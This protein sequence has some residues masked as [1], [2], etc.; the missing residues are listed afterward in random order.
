MLKRIKT[1]LFQPQCHIMYLIHLT[2]VLQLCF[3]GNFFLPLSSVHP[4]PSITRLLHGVSNMPS[5]WSSKLFYVSSIGM[6]RAIPA[7][8]YLLNI[9]CPK[10]IQ[11]F[12]GAIQTMKTPLSNNSKCTPDGTQQQQQQRQHTM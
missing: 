6:L 5:N 12:V 7:K 10:G 4:R 3:T 8:N 2:G 9:Y 11:F 1:A